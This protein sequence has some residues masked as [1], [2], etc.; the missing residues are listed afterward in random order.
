MNTPLVEQS[1]KYNDMRVECRWLGGFS[2]LDHDLLL[3]G[4]YLAKSQ[5]NADDD[6]DLLQYQGKVCASGTAT[7]FG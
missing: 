6:L 5:S 3:D 2:L 4:L 7:R 1:E